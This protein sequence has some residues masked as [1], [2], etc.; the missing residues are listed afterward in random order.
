[1]LR[2][3]ETNRPVIN[4]K[5]VLEEIES[6]SADTTNKAGYPEAMQHLSQHRAVCFF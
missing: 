5:R 6:F 2:G 1:M 4:F 3:Q